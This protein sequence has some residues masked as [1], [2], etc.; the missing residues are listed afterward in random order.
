MEFPT[1]H[2]TMLAQATLHG[3]AAAGRALEDFCGRYRLPVIQSL[4]RRGVLENRVEDMTHD[5]FLRLMEDS[6]LKRADPQRG[7]FRSFIAGALSRFLAEDVK[8]NRAQKRGG[9]EHHLPLDEAAELVGSSDDASF[10]DYHWALHLM[11]RC[12]T[13]LEEEW[14]RSGKRE[15]FTTLR[16]FLP[17]G[18]APVAYHEAA[19]DLG[20]SD[21]ALRSEIS[22]L[23]A[24]FRDLLRSEVAATLASPD[25]IDDEMRHLAAV[26]QAAQVPHEKAQ[27]SCHNPN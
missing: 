21:T 20:I 12:L 27:N 16:A 1:T 17:G 9:G 13:T 22:R 6:A 2:W 8:R 25:E 26:L 5:F 10:L 18:P 3:D 11:Q 19:S 14:Q 4:R 7:R 15:R 23:R 24:R